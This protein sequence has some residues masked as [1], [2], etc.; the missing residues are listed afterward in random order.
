MQNS[1]HDA[2]ICSES[3][4]LHFSF[5]ILHFAFLHPQVALFFRQLARDT[6]ARAGHP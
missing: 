3:L 6:V 4:L 5:F 2:T 1:K